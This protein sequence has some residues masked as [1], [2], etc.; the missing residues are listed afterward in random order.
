[1]AIYTSQRAADCSIPIIFA[2]DV[3]SGNDMSEITFG[4]KKPTDGDTIKLNIKPNVSSGTHEETIENF[5]T[6]QS[7]T[8][9]HNTFEGNK[10][11]IEID[12]QKSGYYVD[13]ELQNTLPLVTPHLSTSDKYYSL[14]TDLTN[15]TNGSLIF[16]L[17]SEPSSKDVI[18]SELGAYEQ[19]DK[20][21]YEITPFI[22]TDNNN[23]PIFFDLVEDS[24]TFIL[25]GN[26]VKKTYLK[27]PTTIYTKTTNSQGNQIEYH[28][29]REII[30]SPYRGRFVIS[31]NGRMMTFSIFNKETK[32]WDNV[33]TFLFD[34][35]KIEGKRQIELNTNISMENLTV[36]F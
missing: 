6:D 26:H 27:S 28:D 34:I 22:L 36:N 13:N 20:D 12:E 1:M 18:Y 7:E 21:A 31:N 11:L 29:T 32:T 30:K 23:N 5:F 14:D 2:F 19:K 10:V 16:F 3:P 4:L 25:L 17:T 15:L 9:E 8:H 33:R 35:E 24:I